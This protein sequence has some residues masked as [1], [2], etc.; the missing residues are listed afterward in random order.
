MG[1]IRVLGVAAGVPAGS[2]SSVGGCC[3]VRRM[4]LLDRGVIVEA[5]EATAP[6]TKPPM[7]T[8]A[9]TASVVRRWYRSSEE[10]SSRPP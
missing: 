10:R 6:M 2:W 5:V 9:R 1:R 3:G 7:G 4:P 8:L